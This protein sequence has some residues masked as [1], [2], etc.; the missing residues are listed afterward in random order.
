MVCNHHCHLLDITAES[1]SQLLEL[2]TVKKRRDFIGIEEQSKRPLKC[3][4][5]FDIPKSLHSKLLGQ[6]CG[7]LADLPASIPR[8]EPEQRHPVLQPRCSGESIVSY[9]IRAQ[10]IRQ[11]DV[12][13]SCTSRIKIIPSLEIRPPI[14]VADFPGE[15]AL[16][17]SFRRKTWL[18][19]ITRT[20]GLHIEASLPEPVVVTSPTNR[21]FLS[22]CITLTQTAAPTRKCR[23]ERPKD[24]MKSQ[25]RGS[26]IALAFISST[27]RQNA[28]TSKDL[29]T[30]RTLSRSI[31][32]CAK[33]Q[34]KVQISKWSEVTCTLPGK[35]HPRRKISRLMQ[36]ADTFPADNSSDTS[37]TETQW[38]TEASLTLELKSIS[39]RYLIPSFE[40]SLI[41]RRYKLDLEVRLAE[42]RRCH[43]HLTLPVQIVYRTDGVDVSQDIA[44]SECPPYV[45]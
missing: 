31:H 19:G 4:F 9:R 17:K 39:S 18:P 29:S 14:C 5:H 43:F 26:L 27:P 7:C 45:R 38:Q 13:A 34:T 1:C 6:D 10:A 3:F 24:V 8:F 12:L 41:S 33:A 22:T 20:Q 35:E 30:T 21:I 32:V 11:N 25:F 2:N 36:Y 23:Q 42:P 16:A 28:P 37:T 15:Y 40:S 44:A